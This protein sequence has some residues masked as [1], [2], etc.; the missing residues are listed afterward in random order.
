MPKKILNK[1]DLIKAINDNPLM[2]E[3]YFKKGAYKDIIDRSVLLAA[4]R[5]DF[6][7]LKFLDHLDEETQLAAIKL[8]PMAISAIV[9]P[10]DKLK[11]L[12]VSNA[13]RLL[14]TI[15][16]K[17]EQLCLAAVNNDGSALEFVPDKFKTEQVCLAA[18]KRYPSAIKFV[19]NQTAEMCSLVVSKQPYD[20]VYVKNQTEDLCLLAVFRNWELLTK[21]NQEFRTNK[22]LSMCVRTNPLSISLMSDYDLDLTRNPDLLKHFNPFFFI[23]V[24]RSGFLGNSV[25]ENALI[26]NLS[27]IFNQLDNDDYIK[28]VGEFYHCLNNHFFP[29]NSKG[30]A[31]LF[32]KYKLMTAIKDNPNLK[33]IKPNKNKII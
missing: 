13:G 10:S 21:I 31:E 30:Y 15:K 17:T 27:K 14:S 19:K 22:L 5:E 12:A 18:I 16:P 7:V 32:E 3:E 11:L 1:S 4:I 26:T 25:K 20:I 24:S 23:S 33:T 9:N 2:L 29:V 28:I 6:S 8:D